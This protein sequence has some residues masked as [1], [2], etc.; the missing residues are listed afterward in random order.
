MLPVFLTVWGVVLSARGADYQA[1]SM[2]ECLAL[3]REKN[4]T[5]GAAREQVKEMVAD[6][7]AARS[8][9]FPK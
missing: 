4:P 1:L 7:K 3:A 9:F 6:Y 8:K 2:E 5:L